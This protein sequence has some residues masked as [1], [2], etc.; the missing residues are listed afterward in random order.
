[1]S[2]SKRSPRAVF[3][4]ATPPPRAR[5]VVRSRG[6]RVRRRNGSPP[7]PPSPRRTPTVISE[8][9][10]GSE[11]GS[12]SDSEL[13]SPRARQKRAHDRRE[14]LKRHRVQ[15]NEARRVRQRQRDSSD[16]EK[17]KHLKAVSDAMSVLVAKYTCSICQVNTVSFFPSSCKCVSKM[18]V[19]CGLKAAASNVL[20]HDR[21]T[22]DIGMI[23]YGDSVRWHNNTPNMIKC[24]T[25][26][27][28][29]GEPLDFWEC[30]AE[31]APVDVKDKT[32]FEVLTK[33]GMCVCVS[34]SSSSS[35]DLCLQHNTAPRLSF[36]MSFCI[37]RQDCA[38]KASASLR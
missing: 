26:R 38:R 31:H 20:A 34:S 32:T 9:E 8:S 7:P 11:S 24:P 15:L 36:T 28:V 21:E 25:C 22:G 10:S 5:R 37:S 14:Q 29:I 3:V 23:V 30:G 19:M 2:E 12:G 18:C 4:P 13:E 16:I 27:A 6:D 35:Y 17:K 33:H 1:M